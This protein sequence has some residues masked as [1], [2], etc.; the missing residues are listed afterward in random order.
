MAV[1]FDGKDANVAGKESFPHEKVHDV[2]HLEDE[3]R[4]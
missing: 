2:V 1:I 4:K 3:S